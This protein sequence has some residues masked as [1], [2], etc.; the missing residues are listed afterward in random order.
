MN[1]FSLVIII[2]RIPHIDLTIILMNC[3]LVHAL[4]YLSLIELFLQYSSFP[5]EFIQL[6]FYLIKLIIFLII[7]QK[8]PDNFA[9]FN[10]FLPI[11]NQLIAE[12]HF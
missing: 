9:R 12:L 11:S 7:F 10:P 2:I 3:F 4:K 6:S 5:A 8:T 1:H